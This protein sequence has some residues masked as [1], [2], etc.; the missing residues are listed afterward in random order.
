LPATERFARE[1]RLVAARAPPDDARPDCERLLRDVAREREPDDPEREPEPERG[2][3]LEPLLLEPLRLDA[4][5]PP[6]P[7]RLDEL[8]LAV[9]PLLP[10]FELPWAILASLISGARGSVHRYVV[11]GERFADA[12]NVVPEA[13]DVLAHLL[14]GLADALADLADLLD[15]AMNIHPARAPS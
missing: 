1:L 9:E 2:L 3:A 11:L 14:A 15:D 6:E 8:R 4:E 12:L 13:V 10:D 7:L 5:R